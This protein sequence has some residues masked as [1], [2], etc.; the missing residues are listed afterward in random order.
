MKKATYPETVP[1]VKQIARTTPRRENRLVSSRTWCSSCETR[2]TERRRG[3]LPSRCAY[4]GRLQQSAR[5]LRFS[6]SL[7]PEERR[8]PSEMAAQPIRPSERRNESL[9]VRDRWHDS[10]RPRA[11]NVLYFGVV[12]ALVAGLVVGPRG[13][14]LHQSSEMIAWHPLSLSPSHRGC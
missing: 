4:L 9:L 6:D 7:V 2:S 10:G 3:P 1:W 14:A 5:E 12:A 8:V 13:A 11:H